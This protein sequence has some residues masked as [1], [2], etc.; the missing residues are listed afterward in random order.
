MLQGPGFRS[1]A[2]RQAPSSVVDLAPTILAHL[3]VAHEALDGRALQ[4]SGA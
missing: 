3:G 2:V 4:S 1:G